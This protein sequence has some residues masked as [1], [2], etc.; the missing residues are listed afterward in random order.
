M[1]TLHEW[2]QKTTGT[3]VE[4]L[5]ADAKLGTKMSKSTNIDG[6]L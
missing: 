1:G 5:I 4:E 3:N 6:K 2:N